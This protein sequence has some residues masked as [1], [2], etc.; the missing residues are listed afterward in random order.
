MHDIPTTVADE[1][2]NY[3]EQI[4]GALQRL[5]QIADVTTDIGCVNILIE[6]CRAV[7]TLM[8]DATPNMTY[9]FEEQTNLIDRAISVINRSTS[10]RLPA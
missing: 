3:S 8:A 2:G 1:F 7:Q 4:D 5:R 9:S 6:E 10:L